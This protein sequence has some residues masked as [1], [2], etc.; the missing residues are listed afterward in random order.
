[1][2]ADGNVNELFRE[3]RHLDVMT[4]DPMGNLY[5]VTRTF[6]FGQATVH[7]ISPDGTSKQVAANSSF[8]DSSAIAFLN[9]KLYIEQASLGPFGD[10]AVIDIGNNEAVSGLLPQPVDSP[11]VGIA[12]DASGRL[13]SINS[14]HLQYQ[15]DW[16]TRKL[17]SH[18]FGQWKWFFCLAINSRGTFY[19]S[20]TLLFRRSIESDTGKCWRCKF[21]F[22]WC[23][24]WWLYL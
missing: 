24:T 22:C 16:W 19:F 9:N 12:F 1:M 7:K 10:I 3:D 8:S 17:H 23:S 14:S 13:Y 6:P 18:I 2:D 5:I 11:I 15:T 4:V 20:F 21:R